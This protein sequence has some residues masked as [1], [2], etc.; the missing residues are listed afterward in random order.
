[1]GQ[2]LCAGV[3]PQYF[4]RWQALIDSIG[5]VLD[6]VSPVMVNPGD[7]FIAG[8]GPEVCILVIPH[9]W[10]GGVSLIVLARPEFVDLR[11]SVVTDLSDHDQI[12]LGKVVDRWAQGG[13]PPLELIGAALA[14]EFQRPIEWSYVYQGGAARPRRVRAYL[15]LNGKRTRLPVFSELSLWPWPRREVVERTSL[16]SADPPSFR[17]PLSIDRLLKQA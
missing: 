6:A 16:S 8:E 2:Y 11:W 3:A 15:D 17:L 13:R 7:T 10:L 4:P 14:R 12:D 9:H 1:V 5:G